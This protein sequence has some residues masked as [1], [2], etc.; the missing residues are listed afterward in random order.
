MKII[1]VIMAGGRGERFWPKSRKDMPKQFHSL[2][3]NGKTLIQLT[4]ERLLGIVGYEDMY[5]VTNNEYVELVKKQLPKVPSKNILAEPKSCNTAP[6]IAYASAIISSNV[7]EAVMIVLPADHIIKCDEMFVDCIKKAIK[8]AKDNVNI[9]TIGIPPLYPEV[10]YGYIKYGSDVYCPGVY[11]ADAFIEKPSHE[12]AEKYLASGKYLWNSGVFIWKLSTILCKFKELLPDMHELL[13]M[14]K[15]AAGTPLFENVLSKCYSSFESISIDY[16]IIERSNGIY[17]IP[18]DFGWDDA[19]SWLALERA[20]KSDRNGNTVQGAVVSVD[21]KNSIIVGNKKLIATLGV[22]DL[23]VVDT[24]DAL[25]VCSK[26][27]ARD[28]KK[29]IDE[30]K[31]VN[32]FDLV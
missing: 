3:E 12:L 24:D 22:E 30:L 13:S 7:Q 1:S 8:V 15:S 6:C 23:V 5:I 20:R 4:T 10:G 18:G 9:V 27:A 11:T 19:G 17:V 29:I 28:I 21:T 14:I 32:R 26:S 25:L 16:G 31:A 2:E